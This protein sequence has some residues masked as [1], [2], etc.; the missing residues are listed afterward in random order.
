MVQLVCCAI[1]STTDGVTPAMRL[2]G[3]ARTDV[4][5]RMAR[6]HR[7]SSGERR[8]DA[9]YPATSFTAASW[10][11]REQGKWVGARRDEARSLP[12]SRSS[13]SNVRPRGCHAD[14]EQEACEEKVAAV[15]NTMELE[16][17]IYSNEGER[18]VPGEEEWSVQGTI[19][20]RE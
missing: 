11:R 19:D 6:R 15:N 20:E 17:M 14:R 13:D 9:D 3:G 1:A 4:E 2:N 8:M 18:T 10:A 12:E 5:R 7:Q 16:F